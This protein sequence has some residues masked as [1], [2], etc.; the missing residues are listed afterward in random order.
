MD[1]YQGVGDTIV[2]DRPVIVWVHGGGWIG[3]PEFEG[4]LFSFP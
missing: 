4:A 2:D 1:I 3:A